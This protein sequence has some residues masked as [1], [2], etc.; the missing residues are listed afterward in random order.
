MR[1]FGERVGWP[2]YADDVIIPEG[3]PDELR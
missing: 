1:K 2:H 3:F